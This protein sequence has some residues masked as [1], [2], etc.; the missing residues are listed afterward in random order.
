MKMAL[1][2]ALVLSAVIMM[3]LIMFQ[4]S[5]SQGLTGLI[6]GGSNENF[7][8]KNKVNTREKSLVRYTVV[9]AVVFIGS[10]I[11]LALV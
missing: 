6:S 8:A 9:S 2:I 1:T 3:I 10:V 5:K 11:G 7:F 4:K